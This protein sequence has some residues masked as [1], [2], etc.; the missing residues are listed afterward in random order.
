MYGRHNSTRFGFK[1]NE[2]LY[3]QEVDKFVLRCDDNSLCLNVDKKKNDTMTFG[4]TK[5]DIISLLIKGEVVQQ[6]SNYK[7]LRVT[8]DDRLQWS[9]HAKN[10]KSKN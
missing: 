7:Y 4:K 3:T 9:D 8:I 1:D 6:V 5:K 10:N 2:L